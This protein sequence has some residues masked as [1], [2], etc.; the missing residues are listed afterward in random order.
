VISSD[1]YGGDVLYDHS[2]KQKVSC[3]PLPGVY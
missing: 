1:R 2:K 3:F